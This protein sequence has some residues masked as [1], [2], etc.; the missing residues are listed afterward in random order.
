MG[1][2]PGGPEEGDV[3][4]DGPDAQARGGAVP[5]FGREIAADISGKCVQVDIQCAAGRKPDPYVSGGR[6]AL[7]VPALVVLD[8][9]VAALGGGRKGGEHGPKPRPSRSGL[10]RNATTRTAQPHVAR[11]CVYGEAATDLP[12]FDVTRGRLD[13]RVA[14]YLSSPDVTRGQPG[15]EGSCCYLHVHIRGGDVDLQVR[16]RWCPDGYFEGV[17]TATRP[18]LRAEQYPTPALLDHE[19]FGVP[20]LDVD[21]HP[22][23]LSWKEDRFSGWQV[24]LDPVP[25]ADLEFLV[26]RVAHVLTVPFILRPTSAAACSTNSSASW[27]EAGPS[28]S[29][30]A[31]VAASTAGSPPANDT[32][33][34]TAASNLVTA[35]LLS[36]QY[37]LD[38]RTD[39]SHRYLTS[40]DPPTTQVELRDRPGYYTRTP[41]AHA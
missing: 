13:G 14:L 3:S 21:L 38:L 35:A 22:A 27:R 9:E 23:R 30:S 5:T 20:S 16:T 19:I 8:L 12:E 32:W 40:R 25:P 34:V 15:K 31:R 17:P 18:L 37:L 7:E 36:T 4:R 10:H 2:D 41:R 24:D 6:V 11:S 28:A 29:L 26:P 33:L 39:R 1:G